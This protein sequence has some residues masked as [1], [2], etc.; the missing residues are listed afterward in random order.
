[1]NIIQTNAGHRK[2]IICVET[3]EIFDSVKEAGECL[4]VNP[5]NISHV[6]KGRQN[7]VKGYHFEYLEV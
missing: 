3:R 5:S 7:S 2:K 4:N 1:M 6:L